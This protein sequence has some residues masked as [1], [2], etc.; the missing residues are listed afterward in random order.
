MK[1]YIFIKTQKEGVH[2][3]PLAETK[4]SLKDVS[5]LAY[6][7]RHMFHFEVKI[8]VTHNDRELE[9]ILVKRNVE[10]WLSTM[11]NINYK[12]CEM[13]AEDLIAY[14][15]ACYGENRYYQV[16]VSEDNENG[17]IVEVNDEAT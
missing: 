16:I 12:S 10:N 3:Y 9:F 5:F 17:A 4:E 8:S 15:M 2:R 11:Y 13:L 7:H 1:R 14:L 6:P